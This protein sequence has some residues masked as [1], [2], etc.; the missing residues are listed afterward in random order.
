MIKDT[1]R[2]NT[3]KNTEIRFLSDAD[4]NAVSGGVRNEDSAAFRAFVLGAAR[5]YGGFVSIGDV[6]SGG[7]GT[8]TM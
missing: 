1:K 4:L 2:T 7:G 3:S 5:G 8:T 6:S